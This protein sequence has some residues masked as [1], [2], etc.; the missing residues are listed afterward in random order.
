MKKA[1]ELIYLKV[2]LKKQSYCH[3]RS[4]FTPSQEVALIG[5][6]PSAILTLEMNTFAWLMI[7]SAE[8]LAKNCLTIEEFFK[9]ITAVK[10]IEQF[11]EEERQIKI[12]GHCHQKSLSSIEATLPC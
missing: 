1:E 7:P 12:H 11:S 5:I 10:P 4:Y 8:K 3:K 6:E 9:R 2:F